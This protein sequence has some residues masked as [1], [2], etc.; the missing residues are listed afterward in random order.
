MKCKAGSRAGGHSQVQAK[1][2]LENKVNSL[3]TQ[4]I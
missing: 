1:A 3:L 2:G 4:K